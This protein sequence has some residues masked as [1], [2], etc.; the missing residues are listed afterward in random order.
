MKKTQFSFYTKEAL[1]N[2]TD[3]I[4]RFAEEGLTAHAQSVKERIK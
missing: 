3:D 4:I 1:E 2:D